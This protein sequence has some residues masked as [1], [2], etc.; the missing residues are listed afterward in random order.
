MSVL[1]K[2]T[3]KIVGM[4]VTSSLYGKDVENILIT[5]R[6]CRSLHCTHVVVK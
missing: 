2:N 6:F 4:A 1:Y 3:N 5:I